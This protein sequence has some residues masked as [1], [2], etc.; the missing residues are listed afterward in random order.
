ML[1]CSS[2]MMIKEE[3]MDQNQNSM[4]GL[5]SQD[6]GDLGQTPPG[7]L[8]RLSLVISNTCNLACSYCYANQGRYYSDRGKMQPD[9]ALKA[10]NWAIRTF[11]H[12]QLINFFGGEPSLN[13]ELIELVCQYFHFL[14]ERQ[15]LDYTP[16]YGITTNGYAMSGNLLDILVKNNFSVCVS[17]M[18]PNVCMIN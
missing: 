15:V 12:I 13:E 10:V 1:L 8:Y 14:K 18:D 3:R 7:T 4:Q 16:R 9:T 2:T 6:H 5:M 17:I 11:P